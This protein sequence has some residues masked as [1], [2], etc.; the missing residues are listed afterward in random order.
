MQHIIGNVTYQ[1]IPR[2]RHFKGQPETI[3]SSSMNQG[4]RGKD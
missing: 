1:E 4:R 2:P 3:P